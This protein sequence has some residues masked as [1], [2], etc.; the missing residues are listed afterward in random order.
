M[1]ATSDRGTKTKALEG[2]ESPWSSIMKHAVVGSV[3]HVLQARCEL[4]STKAVELVQ[5]LQRV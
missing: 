3:C 4:R 1:A 2:I 5:R